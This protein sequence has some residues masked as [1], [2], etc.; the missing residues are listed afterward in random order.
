MQRV[1]GIGGVFFKSKDPQNLSAWYE[2]HLGLK[3]Q[4][5]V[6]FFRWRDADTNAPG[7]TLLS[8]FPQDSRDRVS[9]KPPPVWRSP[10]T[11][12]KFPVASRL[13]LN[14]VTPDEATDPSTVTLL[15]I[16]SVALMPLSRGS[17]APTAGTVV[18]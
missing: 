8:F 9:E 13:A 10:S 6:V 2:K 18:S 3:G 11:L 5:N 4:D 1:T 17:K 12:T 14:A 15:V 16:E 7:T